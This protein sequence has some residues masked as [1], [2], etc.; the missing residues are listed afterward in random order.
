MKT[1]KLTALILTVIGALNW[2]L[3]GIFHYDLVASLLGDTS[4]L[5]RLVYTLVGISGIFLIFMAGNITD[6]M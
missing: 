1:I 6:D 5:T 4:L 3:V 2:G